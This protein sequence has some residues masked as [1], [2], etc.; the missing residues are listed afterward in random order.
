MNAGINF[1]MNKMKIRNPDRFYVICASFISNY[2]P[3]NS[4]T[5]IAIITRNH[6]HYTY[7]TTLTQFLSLQDSGSLEI[8]VGKINSRSFASI[9]AWYYSSRN[10]YAGRCELTIFSVLL[11][12]G[13]VLGLIWITLESPK[14]ERNITVSAGILALIGATIGGRA[15]YVAVHWEYFQDYLIEIPKLWLGGLSWP[16]ALI[17]GI[18]GTLLASKIFNIHLGRLADREIPLL[19]SFSVAIWLGCWL[20]GCAYGPE[21]IWGLPV[22]DEWGI[23]KQRLPVQLNGAILTVAL[24]WGIESLR[25]RKGY[26]V[27][28]LA[29]SLG[30]A[31]LSVI[32]LITSLLRVDPY[33]TYYGVRLETWAA[34]IFLGI[35][36]LCGLLVNFL[37]RK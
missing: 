11:A 23:W 1:T 32:L 3:Q 24:F 16:G 28:G 10:R 8:A 34:L 30:L 35:A 33:P 4:H 6:T 27:P 17:G 12:F 19:A 31:G 18:L 21:V 7:I 15:T 14:D 29:A 9:V 36:T 5:I 26:L 37:E 2:K 25:H 22:K 13:A 20:I